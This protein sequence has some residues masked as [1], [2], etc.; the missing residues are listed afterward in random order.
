[1]AWQAVNLRRGTIG[2]EGADGC[3]SKK[4]PPGARDE[5]PLEQS[6]RDWHLGTAARRRREPVRQCPMRVRAQF[7]PL[8]D[9]VHAAHCAPRCAAFGHVILPSQILRTVVLQW[10]AGSPTLLGTPMH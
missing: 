7:I 4:I 9:S 8:R 10:N 1:M 2:T 5:C 3:L 6:H